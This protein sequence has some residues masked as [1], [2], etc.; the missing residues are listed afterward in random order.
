MLMAEE[1]GELFSAIRKNSK[2][3]DVATDSTID[4]VK[5][6]LADVFIYLCSI[7]NQH[8]IDLEE[9]FREE[10]EINKQRIWKKNK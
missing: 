7:A 3:A 9:A 6:E 2:G 8:N 5:H 4:N 1:M 10:E